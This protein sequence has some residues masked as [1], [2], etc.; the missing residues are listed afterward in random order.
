MRGEVEIWDGEKLLHKESNLLVNGAG[1]LLADIMTMSPS[2]SGWD[3]AE[4]GDHDPTASAILDTSNY[5]IQAISFGKDASACQKN[6]HQ[7][8]SRRN[9]MTYTT[10]SS[11]DLDGWS[12]AYDLTYSSTQWIKP[13]PAYASVPSSIA[14]V[15]TIEDPTTSANSYLSYT[16]RTNDSFS[17][18]DVSAM[19]DN[20]YCFSVYVKSPY[21]EIYPDPP[22]ETMQ[23]NVAARSH[24]GFSIR[25]EGYDGESDWGGVGFSRLGTVIRWKTPDFTTPSGINLNYA[26]KSNKVNPDRDTS[27]GYSINEWQ[28][29][30]GAN[31]E[32]DGWYRVWSAGLAP[33]SGTSGLSVTIYPASFESD[34]TGETKQGLSLFGA[35]IEMGRWPT[36][37]QFNN[38]FYADNWDMSGSVLN[39]ST[40]LNKAGTGAIVSIID[41]GTV[42]VSGEPGVSSYTPTNHLSSPPN[43]ESTRVEDGD[44]AVL[45]TSSSVLTNFN[46]GQNLNVI[47]YRSPSGT[48]DPYFFNCL[49]NNMVNG[50]EQET[51]LNNV[52]P[53]YFPPSGMASIGPQAYL[54]GC[55]PEGSSTGGS[56]WRIVSALDS[57]TA[58][59]NPIASGVAG[60]G[61]MYSIFNEASSMDTSGFVNMIM[62]RGPSGTGASKYEMSSTYSG[63]CM[64]GFANTIPGRGQAI[65]AVE[66]PIE[67]S[68]I[69]GSGDLGY[70]NFYGGI[71]NMGLWTIDI[72]ESLRAGNSPPY[73]FGPLDNPRK[74]RLFATKHFT[75]N[76][77][78]IQDHNDS[79]AGTHDAGTHSYKDL[80]IKWRIHFI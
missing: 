63:L 80:T 69:I 65:G 20:W 18:W 48:Y 26:L 78:H 28:Q 19:D 23:A 30:G 39:R 59:D 60:N 36:D 1:E 70:S 47:P 44:T 54:L 55:Y 6:A 35:Q 25:G 53:S 16:S 7:L 74:Y 61:C 58:Y 57:S 42:R 11:T 56:D 49:P 29:N 50:N 17:Q 64:S 67:Y 32:G 45:D 41:K 27:A 34:P 31:Y 9:L 4:A 79:D 66:N 72:K 8:P 3:R 37:L 73:S 22:T 62:S 10:P 40:I 75:W 77:G 15:V 52:N 43:P 13:P 5:T 12:S 24:F 71:Y 21:G 46:I 68:V 51:W 2:L 76:L 38:G 33:V 14:H